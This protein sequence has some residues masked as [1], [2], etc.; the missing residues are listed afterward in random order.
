MIAVEKISKSFKSTRGTV[1]VLDNFSCSISDGD[2]FGIAGKSGAGKSTLLSI[3][4]GLQEPDSGKVLIEGMDIFSLKDKERSS[5]RNK[6]IGFVSQEQSFISS[7]TVKDNV[8]L[9][10]FLGKDTG[11][12]DS[13]K[14]AENL[15]E[16]LGIRHLAD[17]FPSELSGGE[18]H[19]VLI[20]RAL[21]NNPS[22]IL[23]DE[24][25][26]SL[27]REQAESVVQIFRRLADGG[28]TIVMV[29]H[30][31]SAL[32]SCDKIVHL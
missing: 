31:E 9:P 25:T 28:K 29:S 30:D 18:N 32:N 11:Q 14:K 10:F 19:R 24:P 1:R 20:A 8:R 4:A 16:R 3:I 17:C 27:D 7:L 26:S 23:A 5:F 12:N 2:F 21:M 6:K 22:V 15:L 13:E